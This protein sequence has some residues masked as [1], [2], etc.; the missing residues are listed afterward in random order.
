MEDMNAINMEYVL[1]KLLSVLSDNTFIND[2][3]NLLISFSLLN[4]NIPSISRSPLLF[5]L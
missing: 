1:Q 5:L 2:F 4:N 3:L